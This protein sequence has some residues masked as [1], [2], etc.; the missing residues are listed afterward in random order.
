MGEDLAAQLPALWTFGRIGGE[1][2]GEPV[3]LSPGLLEMIFERFGDRLGRERGKVVR[4]RVGLQQLAV[5][6]D[7]G[8][9]LGQHGG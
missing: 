4:N 2:V 8:G 7:G 5:G 9:K 6:P 3:L 1:Q